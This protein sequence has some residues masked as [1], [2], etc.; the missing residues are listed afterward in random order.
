MK[1]LIAL[2][3]AAL[4]VCAL[5]VM[6]MAEPTPSP[7]APNLVHINIRKGTIQGS[8]N[9]AATTD[10]QGN[11][12]V[13]A[14]PTLGKFNNWTIF[15][16]VDGQAQQAAIGTT[17]ETKYVAAVEGVDYVIVS[18]TLTTTT[19]TV[20]PLTDLVI[21]GNYDGKITDP[22]T[23]ESGSTAPKTGANTAVLIVVAALAL[24][25]AGYATKKG[26]A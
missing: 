19:L 21:C 20:R 23:G 3:L 18:G 4:I 25:G 7:E 10:G 12:T 14:D 13:V 8:T 16:V 1:K 26:L 22:K 24:A 9:N 2:A 17:A 5:P 6:A 11:I 15:K